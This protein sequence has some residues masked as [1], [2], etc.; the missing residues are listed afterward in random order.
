M[1]TQT[2]GG[3]CICKQTQGSCR[4]YIAWARGT[5]G[6]L[7]LLRASFYTHSYLAGLEL[8]DLCH[9]RGPQNIADAQLP[10][11][12]SSHLAPLLLSANYLPLYRLHDGY[13][14][15]PGS[16][17]GAG[18]SVRV[19]VGWG[20]GGKGGN[21]G[22]G[23]CWTRLIRPVGEGVRRVSMTPPPSLD[24]HGEWNF[25]ERPGWEGCKGKID[26]EEVGVLVTIKRQG[27]GVD[28]ARRVGTF[29]YEEGVRVHSEMEGDG[30]S[31]CA[32]RMMVKK[33]LVPVCP[34]GKALPGCKLASLRT[35]I[36]PT[37][38]EANHQ[39]PPATKKVSD[40]SPHDFKPLLT[41]RSMGAMKSVDTPRT[42]GYPGNQ[43]P[44]DLF[45]KNNSQ[46]ADVRPIPYTPRFRLSPEVIPSQEF[47]FRS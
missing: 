19:G 20:G 7:C 1:H 5:R 41:P 26:E 40:S 28:V 47:C 30:A 35:I 9:A 34:A 29:Q 10:S 39:S 46:S 11:Y 45:S 4:G 37:G 22:V 33:H 21:C 16:R 38:H 13:G 31:A 14:E 42:S 12:S 43:T 32:T 8:L 24:S 18:Y 15:T 44:R 23:S 27:W 3:R 2:S 17:P 6:Q 25:E 36:D